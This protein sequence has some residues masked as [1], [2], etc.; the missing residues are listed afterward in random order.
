[1]KSTVYLIL[2]RGIGGK[3][4]L[5]VQALREELIDAGFENVVRGKTSS[6]EAGSSY[7]AT[8]KPYYAVVFC[9]G[10]VA[11]VAVS[12]PLLDKRRDTYS[13]IAKAIRG[14]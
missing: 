14:H 1:M 3:T 12:G 10:D 2:F 6:G 9:E 11:F 7:F 4:Q 13:K 5:P 8:D